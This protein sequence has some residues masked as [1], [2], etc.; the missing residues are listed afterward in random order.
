MG[1]VERGGRG[2]IACAP[3]PMIILKARADNLN[4]D[5]C[6]LFC[7]SFIKFNLGNKNNSAKISV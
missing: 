7:V 5:S 6:V 4:G 1:R 2:T 3:N